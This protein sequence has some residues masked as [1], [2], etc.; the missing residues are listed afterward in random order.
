MDSQIFLEAGIEKRRLSG[1]MTAPSRVDPLPAVLAALGMF[2][3]TWSK[4]PDVLI[5]FGRELY[6]PW[7]LSVG[8]VLYLDIAYFN[9]PLSPYFN[10]LWFRLFGPHM[11]VL[12]FINLAL[13]MLIIFL[14]Y[15]LAR[16][17]SGRAGAVAASLVFVAMFA[18]ADYDQV[19]NYNYICPYSHE[20]VH[21]ILLSFAALLCVMIYCETMKTKVL[22]VA[23]LLT[24]LVFLTKAEIFLAL[25]CAISVAAIAVFL[26]KPSGISTFPSAVL[27]FLL[28]ALLPP[29][30][31]TLSMIPA[32]GPARALEG[33]AGSFYH[34]FA[35]GD[36]A[37]LPFYVKQLGTDDIGGNLLRMLE[38]AA[39]AAA[40]AACAAA[41][42][43][44]FRNSKL[45]HPAIPA[46]VLVLCG[47]AFWFA[48]RLEWLTFVARPLP[49]FMLIIAAAL[50]V[51]LISRSRFSRAAGNH[52]KLEQPDTSGSQPRTSQ[53]ISSKVR[54]V[55]Q[56][57]FVIFSLVL[58]GKMLLNGRIDGYGFVLAMPAAIV[59]AVLL[60]DWLPGLVGRH[61]GYGA[62][63]L[64]AG[65]AI[66]LVV[67]GEFVYVA[68][69]HLAGKTVR[70][71]NGSDTITTYPWGTAVNEGLAALK[72]TMKPGETMAVV[73][74]GV[75][76][77]YLMRVENPTPYL[78]YLP[79][80]VLMFGETEVLAAFKAHP[81]EY[82]VAIPRSFKEY[83]VEG[84]GQGY[85]ENLASWIMGNYQ[86]LKAI[87]PE[88]TGKMAFGK[89]FILRRKNP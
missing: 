7:Q 20:M 49:L 2:W 44:V 14:V 37:K 48:F 65:V 82:V 31:G 10:S 41:M 21:G 38:S 78:N 43:M 70:V 6:V 1:G 51:S 52:E 46:L 77:N 8:K 55:C 29:L 30:A 23:G 19:G 56:L 74:E 88:S 32:L 50:S 66:L 5:D 25:I 22:G 72:T 39:V 81:P 12:V 4:W 26:L 33:V 68:G 15:A 60:V 34:L 71:S 76:L 16:R 3:W 53:G 62:A 86:M 54:P 89:L 84:F 11:I 63:T 45:R 59:L 85:A 61:G 36:V 69:T 57:S 40:L 64:A 42:G 67:T 58:L 79:P 80:D 75:M 83:G 24:G 17:I 13:L 28:T 27:A 87:T 9:G 47:L 73:P 18:F 35:N